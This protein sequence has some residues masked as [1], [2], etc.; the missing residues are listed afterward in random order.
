MVRLR[1]LREMATRADRVSSVFPDGLWRRLIKAVML[2]DTVDGTF[3]T[4]QDI[5]R[6]AVS[7]AGFPSNV[8]TGQSIVVSHGR[9]MQ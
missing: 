2:K 1:H 8:L 3:T 5:A 7:L 9:F 6:C 4:G